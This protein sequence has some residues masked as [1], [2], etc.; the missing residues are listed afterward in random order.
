VAL[1]A[2][3]ERLLLR[4]RERRA[5]YER[6]LQELHGSARPLL[7]DVLAEGHSP[8]RLLNAARLRASRTEFVAR[9]N[10]GFGAAFE[11][12]PPDGSTSRS[13]AASCPGGSF[14]RGSSSG[15]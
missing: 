4:A 8:A 15:G 3:G 5:L 7:V 10:G 2:E 1:T 6:S 13:G 11:R 14:R 12:L 9:F